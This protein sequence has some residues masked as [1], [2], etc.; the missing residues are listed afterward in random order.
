MNLQNYIDLIPT[1]N[2]A[3]PKFSAMLSATI[4]PFV[5]GINLLNGVPLLFDV[6]TAVGAQL[7]V[8]G[9]WVGVSRRLSFA[10][11]GAYFSWDIPGAG[12]NQGNWKLPTDPATGVVILTDVYYR[13]V[14]KA[15]ILNNQWDGDVADAYALM[16][17]TFATFGYSIG[18][19]DLGNL[20]I[21]LILIGPTKPDS[22]LN[23]IF[24]SGLLD[25]RPVGVQ[26][27]NR[28]YVQAPVP[29]LDSTFILDTSTIA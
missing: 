15:R 24:L 7:D 25:I 16:N 3:M 6:D 26:V 12:W 2:R 21:A 10:L 9:Q 23:S 28:M 18:I 4:Q 11:V 5:D 14:L 22:V 17:A 29:L 1:Q 13:A 27:V 19:E 20:T 8:V